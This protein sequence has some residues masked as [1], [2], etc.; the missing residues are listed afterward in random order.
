MLK[1]HTFRELLADADPALLDAYDQL[2]PDQLVAV[3]AAAAAPPAPG[4]WA[5]FIQ[6]LIDDA[7]EILAIINAIIKM[8]PAAALL[9]ALLL[10]AAALEPPVSTRAGY[11]YDTQSAT[12][13]RA[14]G[15]KPL[16]PGAYSRLKAQSERRIPTPPTPP[17]VKPVDLRDKCPPVLDQG[18]YNCCAACS[19]TM[20]HRLAEILAGNPDPKD[21][22]ADLYD[23]CNDGV[24]EGADLPSCVNA[25]TT[26][27]VAPSSLVPDYEIPTETARPGVSAARAANPLEHATFLPDQ[28]S[29]LAAIER[30]D[31]VYFGIIVTNHF[32]PDQS[33]YIGPYRGI[34][35]GGHAVL[36]IGVS[37]T[38]NGYAY[39]VRNSWGD[40][41]G[42]HG[43]C[44]L[45]S[46]WAQPQVYG[47]F[48]LAGEKRIAKVRSVPTPPTTDQVVAEYR[49][50]P[51]T[52]PAA[53][54]VA[55][56]G[57]AASSLRL[58][59]WSLTDGTLAATLVAAAGRGVN[60]GLAL[61]LSGGSGTAQHVIARQLKAA[62]CTVYDCRFSRQL[63]NNFLTADGSYTLRGNY[64]YSPTAIQLGSYTLAV[65]G[66]HAAH[67]AEGQYTTL[68]SHGTLTSSTPA[69]EPNDFHRDFRK[70]YMTSIECPA[71]LCP[72]RPAISP[73]PTVPPAPTPGPT[74]SALT[75]PKPTEVNISGYGINFV[76]KS[77]RRTALQTRTAAGPVRRL[78]ARWA[79]RRR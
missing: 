48:A 79:A 45:D 13:Y 19:G 12:H 8:F 31:P 67:I 29:M 16:K 70:S 23:R 46:S 71:G 52:G 49:C 15:L 51:T 41:W 64:Y 34:A 33:G 42:N 55:L 22:V 74:P 53:A 62:G 14:T 4:R 54:A 18:S 3:H 77:P 56:A 20:G 35:E 9:F 37:G 72:C 6:M 38:A 63:E 76:W 58:A 36:A 24:D 59:T 47:A 5:A 10:P 73:T 65:S 69:A 78:V 28:A 7:P 2:T 30:G 61:D 66:T 11:H 68:T 26:P 27:G 1:R 57:S 25:M 39:I 17:P 60:V 43:N 21:S 32:Q 40:A 50:P 75:P 44:L